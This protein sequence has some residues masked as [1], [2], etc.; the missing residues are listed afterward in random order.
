MSLEIKIDNQA[1]DLYP[2]QKIRYVF[3]SPAFS[4]ELI[5]GDYSYP[6]TLP[7]TKRNNLLFG[8]ASL[9]ES[10]KAITGNHPAKILVGGNVLV[11]GV[12]VPDKV[13]DRGY[14]G[15]IKSGLAEL[16]ERL[17]DKLLT[18]VDYGEDII[19]GNDGFEARD[20]LDRT[21]GNLNGYP[22][23]K[24]VVFPVLNQNLRDDTQG[25]QWYK[26][27]LNYQNDWIEVS[28]GYFS[29]GW[30]YPLT[31]FFYLNFILERIFGEQGFSLSNALADDSELNR[32]VLYN[33]N[34]AEYKMG[35]FALV[36]A[37]HMPKVEVSKFLV[38]LKKKFCVTFFWDSV[39][40]H[41]QLVF[42]K[43]LL[44][45]DAV[46]WT[47]K[48]G[49][50]NRIKPARYSGVII[51]QKSDPADAFYKEMAPPIKDALD[52]LKGIVQNLS[53][54]PS[55]PDY[56]DVYKVLDLNCYYIYDKQGHGLGW[57]RY[58]SFLAGYYSA[59]YG[60]EPLEIET[61]IGTLI[62]WEDYHENSNETR[63]WITPCSQQKGNHKFFNWSRDYQPFTPRLLFYR[64]MCLSAEETLY[65]FGS[66]GRKAFGNVVVGDYTLAPDGPNGTFEQFF[67]EF[68]T[69]QASH[70]EIEFSVHL[71]IIDLV[72]LDLKKRVKIGG[73]HYLIKQLSLDLPDLGNAKLV[74]VRL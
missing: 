36:P 14:S 49:K 9:P 2:G 8:F 40:K 42:L 70:K 69:V 19:L 68:A 17:E 72:S 63:K 66:S 30:G 41:V 47:K 64:G 13:T 24:F 50:P 39:Q 43:D 18:E 62:D 32:L 65:P 56:G 51:T 15:V 26:D 25:E 12:F 45:A 44:Q 21:A 23:H 11:A 38:G 59:N 6:I 48:V 74:L 58:S 57:H 71:S 35:Q 67:K 52:D 29:F 33:P 7:P 61:E 31:P 22:T 20:Y 53:E 55:E 37:Y 54:L 16:E 27:N 60:K 73:N 28:P 46:D 10:A 4:N 34:E 5:P 3:N 1:V